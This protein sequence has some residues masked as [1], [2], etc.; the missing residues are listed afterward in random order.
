[1]D[2]ENKGGIGRDTGVSVDAITR[3]AVD[4]E[5][6]FFTN[7]YTL[8]AI[9]KARNEAANIAILVHSIH[10]QIIQGLIEIEVRL[11]GSDI[12]ANDESIVQS[13]EQGISAMEGSCIKYTSVR[14]IA[15]VFEP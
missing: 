9:F 15:S 7:F 3:I 5:R 4:D 12:A 6:S 11:G 8:Q 13:G 1:M 2:V 10:I 14:K